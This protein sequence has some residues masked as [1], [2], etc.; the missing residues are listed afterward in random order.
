M[1]AKEIDI[2]KMQLHEIVQVEG[3][4]IFRVAGGWI[5][6][7]IEYNGYQASTIFIPF[8]N[9]FMQIKGE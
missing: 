6:D 9:E 4:Q 5:Y 3:M 2:Y 7:F 1:I 8:N